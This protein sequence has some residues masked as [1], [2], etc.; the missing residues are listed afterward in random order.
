MSEHDADLFSPSLT[1]SVRRELPEGSRPWRLSSQFYVAFFGGPLAVG[2]IGLLNGK[3]LELARERL[4]ALAGVGIAGF[5]AVVVV[6]A[7]IDAGTRGRPLLAG[8]GVV[9]YLVARELQKE[10]DRL[11]ELNRDSNQAYDS[12]LGPGALVVVLSALA[13]LLVLAAVS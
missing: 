6:A 9:S 10:P 5:I 13:S 3:R 1:Q 11:Y 8:A 2:A 7:I 4:W 12:L